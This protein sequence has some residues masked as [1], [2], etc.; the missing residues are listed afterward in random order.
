MYDYDY[1]D[2]RYFRQVRISLRTY[3]FSHVVQMA[4]CIIDV[5]AG[6]R[7]NFFFKSLPAYWVSFFQLVVGNKNFFE[8]GLDLILT[9]DF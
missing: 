6:E 3:I 1:D 9:T 4:L 5:S 8:A 7:K 2:G